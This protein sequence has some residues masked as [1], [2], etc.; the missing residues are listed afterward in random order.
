[1]PSS[2]PSIVTLAL[3]R[4]ASSAG[5]P[6]QMSILPAILA[7]FPRPPQCAA[8]LGVR[9]LAIFEDLHTVDEHVFHANRVL[10]WFLER[11]PVSDRGRIKHND[12]GEHSFFDKA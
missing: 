4:R 6:L 7:D 9:M 1:N 10:V 3:R 5:A 12:I 2:Q 8:G 11:R